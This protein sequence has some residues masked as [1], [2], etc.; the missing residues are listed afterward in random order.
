RA[1]AG[2]AVS[3]TANEL[4]VALG[5]AILGSVITVVYRARID[6]LVAVDPSATD[7]AR[8]TLGAAVT[9]ADRLPEPMGTQLLQGAKAGFV[10]GTQAASAVA[11]VAL[12]VTA[13]WGFRTARNKAA[14]KVVETV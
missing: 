9:A 8:E 14:D 12:M 3:E 2:A 11:A 13:V 4:G 6:S 1:G 7:H 10:S 5:T